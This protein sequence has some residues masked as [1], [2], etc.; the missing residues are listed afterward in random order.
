[1][2]D[3][4]SNE[5]MINESPVTVNE[6]DP[7]MVEDAKHKLLRNLYWWKS[8]QKRGLSEITAHPIHW[9]HKA[10]DVHKNNKQ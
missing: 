9:Y 10:H 5:L 7:T 1:M 2:K 3:N 8:P 4:G 6:I